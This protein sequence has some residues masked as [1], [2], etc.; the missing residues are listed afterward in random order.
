LPAPPVTESPEVRELRD[1]LWK[2]VA[3]L[4]DGT[5]RF[6]SSTTRVNRCVRSRGRSRS[7]S[8]RSRRPARPRPPAR[9]ALAGA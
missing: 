1:R 6:T 7:R 9:G 8:P 3:E 2:Q 5:R 4:P